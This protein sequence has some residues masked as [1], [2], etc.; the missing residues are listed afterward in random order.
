MIV[1]HFEHM[2]TWMSSSFT[3][4]KSDQ[5]VSD[6]CLGP[7]GS[8]DCG[9]GLTKMGCDS[10]RGSAREGDRVS[11]AQGRRASS[12]QDSRQ[13]QPPGVGR[14]DRSSFWSWSRPLTRPSV[15]LCL[16]RLYLM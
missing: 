3:W 7:Q 1:Y 9:C 16:P 14:I 10:P 8:G 5:I 6:P 2:E 11:Q 13:M 4:E 12:S 15:S